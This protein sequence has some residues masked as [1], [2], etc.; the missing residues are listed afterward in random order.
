MVPAAGVEGLA[1]ATLLASRTRQ[2]DP[3]VGTVVAVVVV[4]A[5]LVV[6]VV[7]GLVPLA[8]RVVVAE[9]DGL[10]VEVDEDVV[11]PSEVVASPATVVL[12]GNR[13]VLV[14]VVPGASAAWRLVLPPEVAT[15]TENPSTTAASTPEVTRA[16]IGQSRNKARNR[17]MRAAWAKD[18]I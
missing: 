4:V 8:G 1:L 11:A 17:S 9:V 7:I 16:A 14:V 2:Y 18:P 3:A 5:A 13:V 15:A 6:D 10:V 12:E